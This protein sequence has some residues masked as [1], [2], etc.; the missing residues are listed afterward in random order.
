MVAHLCNSGH[1]LDMDNANE[2]NGAGNMDSIEIK[3]SEHMTSPYGSENAVDITGTSDARL[4]AV[5]G[6]ACPNCLGDNEGG[7]EGY[8]KPCGKRWKRN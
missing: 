3:I 8:C 6:L 4:D 1:Y 5:L 7:Y 2:N